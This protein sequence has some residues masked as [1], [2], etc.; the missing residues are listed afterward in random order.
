ML[1]L[2]RTIGKKIMIGDNIVIKV[3]SIHEYPGGKSVK[4]G[5]EAPSH[6]KIL[7]EE[8][9]PHIND[10]GENEANGFYAGCITGVNL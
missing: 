8:L 7:R 6:V 5:I 10:L 4:I 2:S 3:L 9:S 1:I